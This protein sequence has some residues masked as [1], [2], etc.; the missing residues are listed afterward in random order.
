[1]TKLHKNS[2]D[3]QTVDGVLDFISSE[4]TYATDVRVN[5]ST[6]AHLMIDAWHCLYVVKNDK[7]KGRLYRD[8]KAVFDDDYYINNRDLQMDVTRFYH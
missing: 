6:K 7:S 8:G 1:M 5:E 4:I 2:L 3:K